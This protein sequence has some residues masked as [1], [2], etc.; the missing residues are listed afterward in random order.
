MNKIQPLNCTDNIQTK[1]DK[2]G[3]LMAAD[4]PSAFPN[5]NAYF[6][7]YTDSLDYQLSAC[8][9]IMHDSWTIVVYSK[10]LNS[11]QK[12]YTTTNT[13]NE[14]MSVVSILKAIWPVLHGA[15]IHI[16]NQ[17]YILNIWWPQD[18]A[19]LTLVYQNSRIVA[20]VTLYWM[21]CLNPGE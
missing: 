2:M 11:T 3:L 10:K 21:P 14:M 5:H 20:M 15:N 17:L 12:N 18:P 13:E 4:M 6:T 8:I 7:I 1:F 9:Y 16:L 19:G